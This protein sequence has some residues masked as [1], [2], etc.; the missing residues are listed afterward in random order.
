MPF[1]GKGEPG[2]RDV[3]RI[4][5]AY[6]DAY[7]LDANGDPD[8]WLTTCNS[9]VAR[10]EACNDNGVITAGNVQIHQG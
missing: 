7:A 5:F 10:T 8:A 6:D 3:E 2:T 1:N 4:F 9:G